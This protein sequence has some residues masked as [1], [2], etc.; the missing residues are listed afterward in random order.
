MTNFNNM[1]PVEAVFLEYKFDSFD[2]LV[3]V[4]GGLGAFTAAALTRAPELKGHLFDLPNVVK[5]AQ[6]VRRALRQGRGLLYL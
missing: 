4:G 2:R 6:E 5:Q 3:D 1:C